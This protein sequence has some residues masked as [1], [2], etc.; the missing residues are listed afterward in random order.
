[1]IVEEKH[2][3][4]SQVTRLSM[5][6]KTKTRLPWRQIV[7]VTAL[8]ILVALIIMMLT[9]TSFMRRFRPVTNPMQDRRVLAR[10]HNAHHPD[11]PPVTEATLPKVAFDPNGFHGMYVP[12]PREA[13]LRSPGVIESKVC[14]PCWDRNTHQFM[15]GPDTVC[16]STLQRLGAGY[17]SCDSLAEGD[18][19]DSKRMCWRTVCGI[20]SPDGAPGRKCSDNYF[21]HNDDGTVQGVGW[22]YGATT[23]STPSIH[24]IV[25]DVT[26]TVCPPQDSDGSAAPPTQTF[27]HQDHIAIP[28]I[29]GASAVMQSKFQ[30]CYLD[31]LSARGPDAMKAAQSASLSTSEPQADQGAVSVCTNLLLQH[32]PGSSHAGSFTYASWIAA[33]DNMNSARRRLAQEQVSQGRPFTCQLPTA[34][35]VEAPGG[36]IRV[37][38]HAYEEPSRDNPHPDLGEACLL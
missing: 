26:K 8:V 36:C 16:S 13:A 17:A 18:D 35:D 11:R 14:Q 32:A 4:Y 29:H 30:A 21:I 20:E 5:P 33:W 25:D 28:L 31:V 2:F 37:C 10:V 19:A 24:T 12:T 15:L 27:V 9:G 38:G 23:T 22:G 3:T 7:C 1:M 6:V 34:D